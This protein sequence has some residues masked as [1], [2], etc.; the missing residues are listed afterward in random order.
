MP[1]TKSKSH[2][3][4][5]NELVAKPRCKKHGIMYVQLIQILKPHVFVVLH[6]VALLA[7][8]LAHLDLISSLR[9]WWT[10]AHTHMDVVSPR[11]RVE[12]LIT[13]TCRNGPMAPFTYPSTYARMWRIPYQSWG[14]GWKT[15]W[16]SRSCGA[17]NRNPWATC[18][19]SF[20]P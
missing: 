4:C 15:I 3:S 14:R 5:I 7:F 11:L 18:F 8:H 10:Y 2:F 6:K 20:H 16:S 13:K 19:P 9:L 17:N 12:H 1:K